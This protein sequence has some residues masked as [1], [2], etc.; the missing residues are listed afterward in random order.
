MEEDKW[1]NN[2]VVTFKKKLFRLRGG[3]SGFGGNLLTLFKYYFIS[4]GGNL[5][6]FQSPSFVQHSWNLTVVH[7]WHLTVVHTRLSPGYALTGCSKLFRGTKR[8]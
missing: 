6:T 2:M 3:H 7:E 4:L 5:L 1:G 8:F